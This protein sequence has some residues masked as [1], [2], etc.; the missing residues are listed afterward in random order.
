MKTKNIYS[1]LFASAI[2]IIAISFG[3]VKK[4]KTD[5]VVRLGY[6]N[7]PQSTTTSA[8]TAST[9]GTTS[10]TAGSTTTANPN[11]VTGIKIGTASQTVTNINC[12]VNSGFYQITA[13]TS[14]GDVIQFTF[15]GTTAPLNGNYTIITG[16]PTATSCSL[17]YIK[18]GTPSF[19]YKAQT[20][21]NSGVIVAVSVTAAATPKKKITFPKIVVNAISPT[22]TPPSVT[23]DIVG[24]IVCP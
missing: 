6:K 12:T 20:S 4:K 10:A 19:N 9:A 23:Y 11:D 17:L 5:G 1:V 24:N 22:P 14:S 2:L 8:T 7:D 13:T 16:V 3:C 21:A 18:S 15:A